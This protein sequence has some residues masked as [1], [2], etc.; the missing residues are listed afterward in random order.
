M[1]KYTL[2]LFLCALFVL[3]IDAQQ[4]TPQV[5]RFINVNS[6][7]VAI[8]NVT[9]IDGTGA[10]PKTGQTIVLNKDRIQDIGNTSSVTVPQGAK[11]IDGTGKTVIPGLVMLHE[12]LFYTKPFENWFSV[13]QM[14]FTFPR[15]YL[16]GG[17]T[18]MRTGG[19]IQ[20][21]TDLNVKKWINEGKMTGSKM[22]V[23][24]P[25]IEREGPRVPELGFI[26]NAEE[27]SKIVNY[28]ADKGVTSFKV[29]NNITKEDLRIAVNEA[30]KRGLKVTG[31]LCSLTYEEASEIGIDNLEHGFMAS[32][33]FINDKP[34]NICDPFAARTALANEDLDGDKINRLI[35]LLISNK[36]AVTSTPVVFEPYTGHEVVPGGGLDALAPQVRERVEQGYN[37]RL[38]RDAAS[39]SLFNKNLQWLKRFHE[40]GGLLV[41]GT[42]P[43]GAGRTVAGYANQRTIEIFV[44]AGFSVTEAI[45]IS[46]YNG[47]L[48]LGRQKEIGTV[49]KGKKADLILING[50]LQADIKNIRKMETV[51]KDGVGFDSA[52]MFESVKGQVGF[53]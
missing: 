45:K 43:T 50:D 24:G 53:N 35:D 9:V 21:Q 39:I 14:T 28:W 34:E 51:F 31:H 5:Q 49:E 37:R 15:L 16:A 36:T 3:Q 12:H 23:T 29:Y 2:L 52:K 6:D 33:D 17:V 30:H 11:V 27:V 46:T 13:G 4:F 19:S 8:T 18:T 47:A 20:P 44:E 25:F 26:G 1:K 10:A 22:D 48:F 42:D 40:K 32:S 7:L 41:A 38:N